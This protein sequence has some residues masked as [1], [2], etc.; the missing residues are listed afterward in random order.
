MTRALALALCGLLATPQ[1][2]HA[3]GRKAKREAQAQAE[4]APVGTLS[5]QGTRRGVLELG[6]AGLL[7]GTA[8]GLAAFGTIQFIRAREHVDFCNAAA[9]VGGGAMGI[10]PCVFDPPPLGFAAAG[11]SWGFSVPLLVGAGILFTRGAEITMDAKRYRK[12]QVS[13]SPWWRAGADAGAGASVR[14][15]F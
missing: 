6:I 5:E 13:V 4:P 11:L 2:A 12:A 10:D 8:I 7:A 3:G 14:L 1:V 9:T 15:R